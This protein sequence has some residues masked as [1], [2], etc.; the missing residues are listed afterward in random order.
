MLALNKAWERLKIRPIGTYDAIVV[1]QYWHEKGPS[2]V[3]NFFR[4][5]YQYKIPTYLK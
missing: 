1:Y 4:M 5:N 2:N 3:L